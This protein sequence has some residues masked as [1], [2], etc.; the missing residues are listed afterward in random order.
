ML[1]SCEVRPQNADPNR[2]RITIGDSHIIYPGD[3][4]TP[5]GSLELVKLIINSVLSR[6]DAKFACFDISNFYLATPMDR[7]EYVKIKIDDIPQ[8][9]IQ[10]Y[11]LLPMVHQGWVYFEIVRGCYGLPQ[12]GCL[13]NDLLRTRLKKAGYFETATTP[14]LWKHSWRPIQFCLIV[15]DFGIKYVGERHAH[16][17]Q[18]I[19]Q[20]HYKISEDWDKTKFASIDLKWNYATKHVNRTCRLS[21]KNYITSRSQITYL[22]T[23]HHWR[24]SHHLSWR[25]SNTNGFTGTRQTHHQQCALA[26]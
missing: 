16:H 11:D 8:E 17:L 18:K 21:I 22:Y 23:D 6:H 3:I 20:E 12:S 15:D 2:T 9:F 10:E 4:A 24:Q 19:L 13:A 14:E 7:S 26:P 25:R 5:T 1:S